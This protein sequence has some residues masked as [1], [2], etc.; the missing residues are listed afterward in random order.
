MSA[1]PSAP[2]SM[3]SEDSRYGGATE[4]GGG[5][6]DAYFS[7]TVP[8][9]GG[10]GD[11]NNIDAAAANVSGGG[12]AT[13]AFVEILETARSSTLDDLG[14]LLETIALARQQQQQQ[15][16]TSEK[17]TTEAEAAAE[18]E[19]T[20]RQR[21]QQQQHQR[22]PLLP[23][24]PPLPPHV[25][26]R[27]V[28]VHPSCASHVTVSRKKKRNKFFRLQSPSLS[29]P[30]LQLLLQVGAAVGLSS[31]FVLVDRLAF[32]QACSAVGFALI[33]LL[34]GSSSNTVG[35][36]LVSC[37]SFVLPMLVG[38]VGGGTTA[39]LAREVAGTV[40]VP[41]SSSSSS[42]SSYYYARAREPHFTVA[43]VG[44]N[45]FVLALASAWRCGE[46]A[47]FLFVLFFLS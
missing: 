35:A 46:E 15:Q 36:R 34:I 8:G 7:S 31:C 29:S 33:V 25:R 9:G 37:A 44:F 6:L 14:S 26:P 5:I 28:A 45:L 10:R 30:Q 40:V 20:R 38:A 42:S 12:R 1:P 32:R 13:F 24:A 22:P 41:S 43:L 4:R 17:V 23:P 47:C 39:S 18:E 27:F 19:E 21:Q 16:A 3:A 2:A 11:R